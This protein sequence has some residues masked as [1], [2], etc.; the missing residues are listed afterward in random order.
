M[1]K[2]LQ[3]FLLSALTLAAQAQSQQLPSAEQVVAKM[4]DHDAQRQANLHGYSGVRHYVL[5]NEHHHKRAEM[6]VHVKCDED[7]RKE[8]DTVSESGWG[9]ALHHV[10][11]RLLE[12]EREASL[13]GTRQHSRISP[14]NYSFQMAGTD[15]VNGRR[16]YV[17]SVAPKTDNNYLIDGRIWVDAEDYAIA[18]IEGKPAKSPSF[19]VKSVHFL[20]TYRK[21]GS[22][23]VPESDRSVTDARILGATQLIIDY[24]DYQLQGITFTA[25]TAAVSARRAE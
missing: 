14:E 1:P 20:H 11:P 15:N 3:L 12:S 5:E 23:W 4:M 10:F 16:A 9:A 13:P 8:F 21:E 25:S 19:W 7:G 2:P 22:F 24:K 18:R 17:L 6:V